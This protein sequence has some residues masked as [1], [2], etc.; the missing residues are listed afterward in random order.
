MEVLKFLANRQLAQYNSDDRNINISSKEIFQNIFQNILDNNILTIN[1]QPI[2]IRNRGATNRIDFKIE[3]L[4]LNKLF[5][6]YFARS[7]RELRLQLLEYVEERKIIPGDIIILYIE[8]IGTN[9][10]IRIKSDSLY[11]YVLE[12]K[13][14]RDVRYRIVI[15]YPDGTRNAQITTTNTTTDYLSFFNIN[16]L[17]EVIEWGLTNFTAYHKEDCASKYIG[18]PYD[19]SLLVD[20]F[21]NIEEIL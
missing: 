14:Q 15:E 13:S 7:P 1:N 11:K 2:E 18:V 12:R 16:V 6:A 5:I 21:D 19:K 20:Y 8:T 9:C 4:V 10:N 17:D 3:D